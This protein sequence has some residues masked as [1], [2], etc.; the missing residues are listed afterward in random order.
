MVPFN[1][2]CH[3]YAK[4]NAVGSAEAW[5][6]KKRERR[7]PQVVA[8]QEASAEA[9]SR[10]RA[11]YLK[12]GAKKG[13]FPDMTYGALTALDAGGEKAALVSAEARTLSDLEK[14]R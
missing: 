7:A 11:R 1:V 10:E 5:E 13:A 14:A 6:Q 8:Q 2:M 12:L 9:L 3:V 4:S